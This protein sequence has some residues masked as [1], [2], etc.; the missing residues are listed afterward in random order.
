MSRLVSALFTLAWFAV[1]LAQS[2]V[3]AF[4][5]G[6]GDPNRLRE[7]TPQR[8]PRASRPTNKRRRNRR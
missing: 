8:R 4:G 7:R 2:L 1:G 5:G 3:G 6:Y